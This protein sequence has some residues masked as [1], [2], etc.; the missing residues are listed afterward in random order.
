MTP[1][2]YDHF[3]LH[4]LVVRPH[5]IRDGLVWI[6]PLDEVLQEW[7]TAHP[8]LFRGDFILQRRFQCDQDRRTLVV[9]LDPKRYHMHF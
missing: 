2:R 6:D 4:S 5:S 9:E 1:E 8:D 3:A 7:D